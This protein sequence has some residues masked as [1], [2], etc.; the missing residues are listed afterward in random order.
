M[1]CCLQETVHR[2]RSGQSSSSNWKFVRHGCPMHFFFF[3]RLTEEA[4]TERH[5]MFYWVSLHKALC[6]VL[7]WTLVKNTSVAIPK[8]VNGCTLFCLFQTL[9]FLTVHEPTACFCVYSCRH[10]DQEVKPGL[11]TSAKRITHVI[12]S[13]FLVKVSGRRHTLSASGIKH[14]D[15]LP[16]N[17]PP[18]SLNTNGNME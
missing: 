13:H 10:S 5:M 17:A 14:T 18:C 1:H 6:E 3:N 9:N 11:N 15:T 4:K 2:N 16:K 8:P 7:L 12:T